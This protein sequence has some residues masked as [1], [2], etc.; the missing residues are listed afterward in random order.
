MERCTW[1]VQYAIMLTVL[2]LISMPRCGVLEIACRY[3]LKRVRPSEDYPRHTNKSSGSLLVA[4]QPSTLW[5]IT[6]SHRSVHS[7]WTRWW[8]PGVVFGVGG[9]GELNVEFDALAVTPAGG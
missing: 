7:A 5:T 1:V 6:H 9:H 2:G 3:R 8:G 4:R